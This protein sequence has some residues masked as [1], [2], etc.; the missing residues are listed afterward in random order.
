MTKY[1]ILPME[2]TNSRI[3]DVPRDTLFDAFADPEKLKH[4]WGP[5]GF[6][7]T[8]QTFEFKPGGAWHFTMHASNGADFENTCT[9]SSI[10]APEEIVFIHHLPMHVFT[11]T[12]RYKD[13][14]KATRLSWH[15]E[16]EPSPDNAALKD[17]IT[18]ANEQ[19]FDRL[20]AFLNQN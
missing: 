8:I 1:E 14:G 3:F 10:K 17:F 6:T 19:N 18:A 20:E 12:M 11:M 9:F 2:I 13:E 7:N 16:F 4:W 5:D 15:M